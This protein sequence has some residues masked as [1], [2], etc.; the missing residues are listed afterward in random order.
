MIQKDF[1]AGQQWRVCAP[2][3]SLSGMKPCGPYAQQGWRMS[4]PVGTVMTCDGVKWTG[5]DG[6]P[7]VKWLDRD[8]NWLANDCT[9]SPSTGGM[10][11]SAPADGTLQ[12]WSD[13]TITAT[14]YGYAITQ[15][16]VV[17]AEIREAV[18]PDVAEALFARINQHPGR[19]VFWDPDGGADGFLL[20]GDDPFALAADAVQHLELT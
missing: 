20:V 7:V 14:S 13:D 12:P 9:L 2:G 11:A 4:A 3:V 15:R 6:V 8:G 5:G 16:A 10:W 17:D 18:E 1:K 19:W